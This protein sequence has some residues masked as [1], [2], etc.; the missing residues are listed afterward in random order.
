MI[1]TALEN[2][3]AYWTFCRLCVLPIDAAASFAN[4]DGLHRLK[5]F[6]AGT[7]PGLHVLCAV[8]G[9]GKTYS[10]NQ[11]FH[12]LPRTHQQIL[13]SLE[14]PKDSV[15]L[16]WFNQNILGITHK[17]LQFSEHVQNAFGSARFVTLVLSN[18]DQAMCA[19]RPS[20]LE[21]ITKLQIDS[22][23]SRRFKVLVECS[24]PGHAHVILDSMRGLANWI[25]LEW[26]QSGADEFIALSGSTSRQ[27]VVEY[28]LL[29]QSVTQTRQRLQDTTPAMIVYQRSAKNTSR[30][31]RDMLE[32]FEP[33]SNE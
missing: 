14:C 18:F 24:D 28:L 29:S 33:I 27:P 2:I 5:Q 30:R 22:V 4:H 26:E 19:N 31:I 6:L 3:M 25:S 11:L 32:P 8:K 21:F 10:I 7:D 23:T 13:L 1:G 17:L 20:A 16:A 12:R 9:A 15:S